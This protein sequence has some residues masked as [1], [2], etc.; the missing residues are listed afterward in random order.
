MNP[1]IQL[2]FQNGKERKVIGRGC[3]KRNIYDCTIGTLIRRAPML[4]TPQ[5][6]W[7]PSNGTI[8]APLA[9]APAMAPK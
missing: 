9:N 4:I 5:D 8:K 6:F 1:M 3:R 2:V 7:M